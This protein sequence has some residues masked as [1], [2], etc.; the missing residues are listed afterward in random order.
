MLLRCGYEIAVT[1]E[2]PTAMV[3]LLS[4][5][6]DRLV[7][8]RRAESVFTT[9]DTP[10]SMYLDL[11]GN[12]C[13]RFVAPAGDFEIWGDVTVEDDG[14]P[15]ASAW[16][17]REVPVAELPD[18]CLIYLTG[19]RYCETDRLSQTAWDLFGHLQPG[20]SRVQAVVDFVH[21]RLTFD[22]DQPRS[23]RTALDA[24][25]ERVGVCRDF[26][27]LAIT[28]CRSLNIP[29][30]YVNGHLSGIGGP[31]DAIIDFHAWM[32]VW[33]DGRWHTFDPRYDEPRVGRIVL[34]RGRDAADI[35][36]LSSFGPHVLQRFRVWTYEVDDRNELVG[37]DG[38]D[39]VELP[40][41]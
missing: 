36:L 32:E 9:P 2:Q 17:A 41:G 14:R 25:D 28:L 20:W 10:T 8:V 13:R 38:G 29:A 26:A 18:E 30:R 33:L 19:S 31:L 12:R 24:Y 1:C 27:H 6:P 35:P 15:D 7:D 23:T 37:G 16:D 3:T 40:R 21:Q 34:A 11:Y 4:V 39:G 5:H 22:Y